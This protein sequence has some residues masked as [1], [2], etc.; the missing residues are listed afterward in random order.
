MHSFHP[1]RGR[2]LFEVL[3]LFAA[4][5]A[6]AGAWL[7]TGASAMLGVAAVVALYG[8]VHLFDLRR[9]KSTETAVP[10][11]I[12]FTADARPVPAAVAEKQ[13]VIDAVEATEAA[14]PVPGRAGPGRRSGSRK[15]GGRRVKPKAATAP[16]PT[17]AK[18][19][20]VSWPMA[21]E[22]TS[23]VKQ[24]EDEVAVSLEDAAPAHIAPLFEP[25]PFVRMPR[26]AFG[27]RGQI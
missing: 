3:C 10:Q 2:I 11:R 8:L 23:G 7:Q 4:A 12:D 26:Q 9:P 24:A 17:P 27:R 5:A 18:E 20:A 1:S 15:G 25:D 16:E 14:D 19:A 6:C 13:A 22:V 21:E